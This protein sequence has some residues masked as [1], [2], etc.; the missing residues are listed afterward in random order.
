MNCFSI[1]AQFSAVSKMRGSHGSSPSIYL[2]IYLFIYLL[3]PC[4]AH[5]G[6]RYKIFTNDVYHTQPSVMYSRT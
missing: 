1:Q 3:E 5:R 4:T 2:F 6:V